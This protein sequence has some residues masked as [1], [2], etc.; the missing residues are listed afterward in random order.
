MITSID[1]TTGIRQGDEPLRT[2][3]TYRRAPDGNGVSFG[4]YLVHAGTG[5]VRV[6]GALETSRADSPR[7]PE[8]SSAPS[9]APADLSGSHS[10]ESSHSPMSPSQRGTGFAASVRAAD[11]TGTVSASTVTVRTEGNPAVGDGVEFFFK[12]A[13][14]DDEI[15]RNRQGRQQGKRSGETEDRTHFRIE[16]CCSV[17]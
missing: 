14:A 5:A 11:V 6:G 7:P 2:L 8:E 1:Q 17:T 9:T 10:N 12:L 13:G 3:A 15:G 16:A 4:V